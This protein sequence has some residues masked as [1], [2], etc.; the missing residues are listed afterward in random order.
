MLNAAQ[1]A[2][3][4]KASLPVHARVA[5]SWREDGR[6]GEDGMGAGRAEQDCDEV[7][8]GWISFRRG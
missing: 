7:G 4:V 2:S 3:F 5:Q 8:D 6:G 1:S